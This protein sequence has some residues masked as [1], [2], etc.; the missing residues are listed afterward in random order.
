MPKQIPLPFNEGYL[1]VG[2][3]HQLY[4][5]EYGQAD[6][7]ASIVLHGGPG[8]GCKSSMLDWFDLAQ[9]RVVLFDQRGAG[10]S[11][12]PG[13]TRHNQTWNLVDDIERLRGHL[14]IPRW[15]A[16][17]GSWGATLGLCYAGRYP[18]A[19]SGLILRGV[20]L[21]SPREMVWFFQ[22]L[23]A[24]VPEGWARLT[25][26]WTA[27]QKQ[28]VLQSLTLMVHSVTSQEQSDGARRWGEYEDAVIRAMT[29][30][31][32]PPAPFT[33]AWINKYRV[34]SHYLSQSC[35]LSE[36]AL[37]RCARRAARVPTIVLHGTHD[38]I[39]PSENATR[40]M[41]FMPHA[42]LR[43]IE[44]GTHTPSDPAVS[45][46]LRRAIHDL[47]CRDQLLHRSENRA[48]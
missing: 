36:R 37:F 30:N 46:A 5:A 7:P 33:E 32:S 31:S 2:D 43:W 22:S 34:Q 19:L 24:L 39:C 8:S 6:G 44:K 20:F 3:G 9:Q 48:S 25:A 18:E 15:L 4:F 47:Q 42:E 38:W 12:P 13:E 11:M 27:S 40:L 10:R 41:R 21:A 35:F 26:G 28:H 14:A 29:G 1:P 16:V 45:E 17:G 23:Q